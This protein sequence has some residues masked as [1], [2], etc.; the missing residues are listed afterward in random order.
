MAPSQYGVQLQMLSDHYLPD[1][2]LQVTQKYTDTLIVWSSLPSFS[3]SRYF[4]N[5]V[6]TS[7]SLH[8]P[9]LALKEAG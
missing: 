1:P 8:P 6:G 3:I 5:S 4:F 7:C 9:T 2:T